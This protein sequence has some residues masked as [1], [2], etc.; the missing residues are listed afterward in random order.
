V[1]ALELALALAAGGVATCL[2]YVLLSA[3]VFREGGAM[4][5]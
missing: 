1:P 4:V 5:S 2:R 3:W